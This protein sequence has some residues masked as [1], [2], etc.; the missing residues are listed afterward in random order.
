MLLRN[1]DDLGG[2][3]FSSTW[4]RNETNP[5]I[6]TGQFQYTSKMLKNLKEKR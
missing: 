6:T 1:S 2:K 5:N 4:N 3:F